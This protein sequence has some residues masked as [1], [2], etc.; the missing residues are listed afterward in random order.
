MPALTD[1]LK[2]EK[3][4][5]RTAIIEHS[6]YRARR[7]SYAQVLDGIGRVGAS[8][9]ALGL[10][11]GDRV[12]LWGE[13]SARWAITFYACLWKK[14]VVV[15]VDASFSGEFAE[16]ILRATNASLVCSDRDAGEWNKLLDSETSPLLQSQ[17]DPDT[18][19]EI[20]YT[21]GT[22]G[23][24]KGVMI[25]HGNILANLVPIHD[26][27][28]KYKLYAKPFSP[29]GFVHLIPLSH[30]FG[31]MMGLFIPQ[32]VGG[33]VVFTEPA[34][35]AVVRAVKSCGASAVI[36]VPKQLSLLHHYIEARYR[37]GFSEN[38]GG[39][40]SGVLRKRWK[41]RKIHSEFGWKFWAFISGGAALP[42]EEEEFWSALGYA[43]IQGYGLTETAPSITITHPFKGIKKGSVGK[44][45][46]GLEV[47]IAED[48]EVLVR[49][50]NVSP[51]Y[52]HDEKATAEVFQEGWLHTGDIGVF[53]EQGNL[54]LRGRKKE[55]I[56]TA[57]GL[58]VYPE[59]VERILNS[60]PRVTESAVISHETSVAPTVHA[61][62]VLKDRVEESQLPEIVAAA[63]RKLESFQ[64]IQSFSVWSGV[65]LPRTSTGKLK[66]LAIASGIAAP[67]ASGRLP[68]LLAQQL[69]TAGAIPP[70]R[71]NSVL[72]LSSLDK[73]EVMMELE[74]AT[75]VEIDD[76]EFAR[77]KTV[78]DIQKVVQHPAPSARRNYPRWEWPLWIPVRWFRSL[79]WYGLVFPLMPV[80]IKMKVSGTENL[81]SLKPPVLFV[82]NHQSLIDPPV[83]LKAL[84]FHL[85]HSLATAM[86][87]DRTSIE[88]MAAGLFFNTYPLPRHSVG[89]R[90]ALQHTG[91]LVDRGYSIL[92]FPEGERT[93]DGNL[94][95]FRQGIGVIA[96][97]I[98]L[99][100]V[101]V[102]L[103][104]VF[105]IWPTFARGPRR[106]GTAE[107]Y[108]GRPF[109]FEG[110]EPA[111]ITRTL[112][113]WF[114]RNYRAN[115]MRAEDRPAD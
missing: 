9:D 92:V 84:P 95:P 104:G 28:Q 41:Y 112:E 15:P 17:I 5:R 12:M 14:L 1:F 99:P 82:A 60:D 46:P 83:I 29:L 20:I 71:A 109:H 111:Q 62:V 94:L 70:E 27:Y 8:F 76:A 64:R 31:Q 53:D 68:Q 40:F 58:N 26:E 36:C 72:E 42:L 59:D 89:L 100:V 50:P 101:P 13:N 43:V 7:F 115:R 110:K 87:A 51:G 18:L 55:V 34:P 86:G 30:L 98:R 37:P 48:G 4:S 11:E 105:E 103:H 24:P 88:L 49:G 57:E 73:L 39:G 33:T 85:R 61:V 78:G 56:V 47:K 21:S 79:L 45:L 107:V 54:Q 97:E 108:F 75:G 10:K 80:R 23:E 25:T 113:E 69:I 67:G 90:D 77:A 6:H 35:N 44:K 22:T 66:R 32:I 106:K 102:L 19:L 65:S 63:N 91:R 52:Y 3:Y 38:A 96:K 93:M 74:Q 114:Q 2:F 16:K 81:E